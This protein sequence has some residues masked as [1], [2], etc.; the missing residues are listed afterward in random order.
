MEAAFKA[1]MVDKCSTLVGEVA[2]MA[3]KIILE[4][5]ESLKEKAAQA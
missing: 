4:K 5:R 1:G 3:T 2:R